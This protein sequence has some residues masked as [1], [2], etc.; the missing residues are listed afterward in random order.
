MTNAVQLIEFY[1]E[2]VE[3][4]VATQ[5]SGGPVCKDVDYCRIINP[6]GRDIVERAVTDYIENLNHQI[7]AATVGAPQLKE[8]F[9]KLYENWKLNRDPEMPGVKLK[10]IPLLS[11]AE[12]KTVTNAK[13]FTV[14]QLAE[15]GEIGLG[16]LGMGA[17]ELQKKAKN[18]LLAMNDQGKLVQENIKI[19]EENAALK[20][21]LKEL[22]ETV[23]L[24][25][26]EQRVTKNKK[27]AA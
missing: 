6:G 9:V 5:E 7:K 19:S 18:Y 13:I 26:A 16:A 10:D 25:K 24:M 8:R 21:E 3:D 2:A 12:L 17:R 23:A 4:R 22:Q 20:A 1:Q 11:P 14:E 27:E 15:I